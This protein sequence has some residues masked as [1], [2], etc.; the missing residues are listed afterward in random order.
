MR[1]E[2]ENRYSSV[3]KFSDD[4]RRHLE[5]LP[6]AARPAT[7]SYRAEK[8]F[9]RNRLAVIAAA[10]VLLTLIGG[11]IGTTWQAIRAERQRAIAEGRFAQVRQLANNI[12]FK[13]Y[14]DIKNLPGSTKARQTLVN[15][16]INYLDNL[17]KDESNDLS[18]RR[19]LARAYQRVG[20]VQGEPYQ[21]NNRRHGGRD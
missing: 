10:I 20:D 12:V 7:F 21:A 15:D 4:L 3:E 17:S 6:V 2:P 14:D 5:G 19:E 16:A 11:I 8:F 9:K 18:L 1:K 13:Y